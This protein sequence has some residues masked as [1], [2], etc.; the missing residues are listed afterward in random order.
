MVAVTALPKPRI[1]SRI[2]AL[3]C[4]GVGCM[5][6]MCSIIARITRWSFGA[7][8]STQ[9][10]AASLARAFGA[11]C[12]VLL[13]GCSLFRG[14]VND[15]PEIR[16]WLFATF[17]AGRMCP[18]MLKHS[19]P[20]RLTPGGNVVGRLFPNGCQ[21]R[22]DDQRRTVTIDFSGT[23]YAWTPVAGRVGF[24]THAAVEY[25]ADFSLQSDATYVWARAERLLFEPEFRVGG[26]E[27]RL[28]NWAH[29]QGPVA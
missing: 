14:A 7:R 9:G 3:V 19:A 12:C 4:L 23:G 22:V 15:S 24:A 21:H 28:V 17:G 29:D 20:L 18:E 6:S 10:R 8:F 5:R 13:G 27:N 25:R 26:I 11:A 2:V 16:W 1:V